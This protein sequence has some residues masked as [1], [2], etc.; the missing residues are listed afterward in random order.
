[1]NIN[2]ARVA[3][4]A[5]SNADATKRIVATIRHLTSN[6]YIIVR[7]RYVNEIEENINLGADEVIP[8]EFE[9][10][11]EIFYRVLDKYLVARHDI[12]NFTEEIRS[13]NYEL[14]RTPLSP[15]PQM[16]IDL[17][18]INFVCLKVEKDS[19]Q[20]I[21]IPLKDAKLRDK[22]GINIVAIKRDGKTITDIQADQELRYGD[23]VYV[24]G[25]PDAIEEL[26]NEL[27][28]D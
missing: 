19:G 18:D 27:E 7:T 9:T 17:P 15:K 10:S 3:V 8:E 28:V 20:Y 22:L 2:K 4:I 12:E 1:M 25:K 16:K 26:E 11:I 5:I 21:N 13:H 24:V 6:P 23:A 14:F